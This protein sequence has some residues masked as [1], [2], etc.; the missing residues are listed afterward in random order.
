MKQEGTLEKVIIP[1]DKLFLDYEEVILNDFLKSKA[2]NG[3]AIRKKGLFEGKL[4][5]VYG[6]D[7]EFVCISEYRDGALYLKKAFWN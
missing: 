7:G 3:I 6:D 4:Y 1:V 5:R 2:K